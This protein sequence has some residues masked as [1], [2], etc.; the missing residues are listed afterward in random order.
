MTCGSRGT[1]MQRAPS[2]SEAVPGER[3]E[4]WSEADNDAGI[5][6]HTGDW[7]ADGATDHSDAAPVART[8][9]DGRRRGRDAVARSGCARRPGECSAGTRASL[10]AARGRASVAQCGDRLER[11]R[12]A[13]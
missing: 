12:P 11:H 13:G 3:N 2:Y 8:A 10:M 1:P 7:L 9:A 4:Q 6:T 5:A